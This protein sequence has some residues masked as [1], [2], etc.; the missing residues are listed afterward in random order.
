MKYNKVK[1]RNIS[2]EFERLLH[3]SQYLFVW[4][5][6]LAAR[7]TLKSYLYYRCL[8]DMFSLNKSKKKKMMKEEK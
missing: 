8:W 2:N 1:L 4:T 6:T 5:Q 3:E 7:H